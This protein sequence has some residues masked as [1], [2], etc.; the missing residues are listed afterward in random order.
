MTRKIFRRFADFWKAA[1]KKIGVGIPADRAADKSCMDGSFCS[2]V[3][4]GRDG[5]VDKKRLNF[6]Q[7]R[8]LK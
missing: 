3:G 8:I 2:R 4:A 6:L 7:A 1:A 5:A